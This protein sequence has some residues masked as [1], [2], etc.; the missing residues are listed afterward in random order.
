MKEENK[1]LLITGSNRGTGYAIAKYFSQKNYTI[2]SFNKTLKG[3]KWMNEIHCNLSEPHQ[4][5]S[6]VK[7]LKE[8]TSSLSVCVLNAAVRKL[9]SIREMPDEDWLL[10]VNTNLNANFFLLKYL[11]PFLE[12]VSGRVIIMGSHAGEFYFEEGA[13]YCATKSALKA[14]S[15]VY[16]QETRDSG[17][18]TTLI[19]AGA[20]RNRP[21]TDDDKKIEPEK[22]AEFIYQ[23][24]QTTGN[25]LV[26][27]VEVRPL[28]TVTP[29]D[30][31]IAKIQYI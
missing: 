21:K 22:L 7:Q 12:S 27:E 31:G 30:K 5:V 1:S 26:G 3:E 23:I 24:T 11:T 18:R 19:N 16:I 13:A 25:M 2:Y 20:I 6:A 14:L 29:P 17:I 10:S 9:S 15:E 28:N 8:K 4:I